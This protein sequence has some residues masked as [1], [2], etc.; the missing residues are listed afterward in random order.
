[1]TFVLTL[2]IAS[3]VGDSSITTVVSRVLFQERDFSLFHK[4][5]TG[6]VSYSVGTRGSFLGGKVVGA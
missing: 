2:P 1:M 6:P 4:V 3:G 5:Q